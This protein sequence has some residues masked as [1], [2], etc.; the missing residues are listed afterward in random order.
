[1]ASSILITFAL[2]GRLG[3]LLAAVMQLG[4]QLKLSATVSPSLFESIRLDWRSSDESVLWVDQYGTVTA[5]GQGVAKVGVR[6]SEEVFDFCT[7][8]VE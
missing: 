7:I 6:A 5:V 8:K 1:M 2:I 3:F 4:E